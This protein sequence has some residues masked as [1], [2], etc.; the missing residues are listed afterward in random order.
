F[1]LVA[2]CEMFFLKDVFADQYPRMNTVFK[3]YFQA[4]ALLSIASGAGLFFL[5]ERFWHVKKTLSPRQR[6]LERRG[7]ALW[8]MILLAFF[9]ASTIYPIYAPA[10]RLAQFK[11]QT[12]RNSLISGNSLD[13]LTYLKYCRQLQFSCTI[14]VTSDYDAIRWLNTHVQGIPVIIEAIGDDYS[15]YGRISVFTGLPTLMGWEGHEYQWRANQFADANFASDFYQRLTDVSTI[16]NSPDPHQVLATMARYHA[17]YLYVGELERLKY[18]K[19]NLQR[20]ASFMKIVYHA[21]GVT[22]YQVRNA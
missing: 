20:F 2:G 22:I 13:G 4:W 5:L 19:A 21:E 17:Q 11:P 1:A 6:W 15:L 10:A 18:D 7:K 8:A 3:F 9:L 14:D 12:T 16:Y